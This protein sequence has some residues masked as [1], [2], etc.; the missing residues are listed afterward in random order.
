ML[1][2]VCGAF[3]LLIANNTPPCDENLKSFIEDL[4]RLASPN[5]PVQYDSEVFI[6][7]KRIV[8]VSS[9]TKDWS[10]TEVACSMVTRFY[11]TGNDMFIPIDYLLNTLKSIKFVDNTCD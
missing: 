2:D 8:E 10:L 7:L 5:S 1:S 3:S 6:Q 11:S 4:D 9:V